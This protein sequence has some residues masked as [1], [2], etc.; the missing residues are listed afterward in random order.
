MVLNAEPNVTAGFKPLLGPGPPAED[1]TM[2]SWRYVY[3]DAGDLVGTSDARGCGSNFEY[4]AAGRL[5]AEDYSPCLETQPSY[6]ATSHPTVA[7]LYDVADPDSPLP[8]DPIANPGT[9]TIDPMLLPGRLASVSDRAAKTVT[10]YDGRGRVV[11]IGRKVAKPKDPSLPDA[12][13]AQRYAPR[14]YT[15]GTTYDGADRPVDDST[16]S[17]TAELQ[18][19][20][21]KSVVSTTYTARGTVG[22]VLGSYGTLV[23]G[24]THD[25]DGLVGSIQYGDRANT[26]TDYTYDNRRRVHSV[27]TYRGPPMDGSWSASPY[28]DTQQ[29]LLED[30]DYTYDVV[31]NPTE[32]RDWRI[33]SEWP[34]G[35]KPVSRKIQYDDLYRATKVDYQYA[36]G[37]DEWKSPF[38]KENSEI[39]VG[40]LDPLRPRPSPHVQFDKRMLEQSFS[41]DW[42]GNTTATDDDAHGFYDRSLGAVTNDSDKRYQLKTATQPGA[43]GGLLNATYDDAGNLVGLNVARSGPCLGG[44]CTQAFRYEWDEV[45]RIQRA[46]RWDGTTTPGGPAAVELQYAYDAH[47]QRVRKTAIDGG[48]AEQ[49]HTLY[50][51]DSLE[52]RRATWTLDTV[53]TALDYEQTAATEA[54][55]LLAHG[56]RLARL[57]YHAAASVPTVTDDLHV[58]LEMGDHL[59]STAIVLD[60]GTGELVEAGTYTAYG[61][62]ESDYRPGRWGSFREDYRFTGKEEDTEVGLTYFGKRYL[63][64]HL[65][66]WVSADPLSIHSFEG[67]LNTYAYVRGA[68]LSAKDPSGLNPV[69][70]GLGVVSAFAIAFLEPEIANAPGPEDKPV[71]RKGMAGIALHAIS[72]EVPIVGAAIDIHENLVEKGVLPAP[73]PGVSICVVVATKG[74]A[75]RS[76]AGG[77]AKVSAKP[78]APATTKSSGSTKAVQDTAAKP[79]V[80]SDAAAAPPVPDAPAKGAAEATAAP[81]GAR[82]APRQAIDSN[83]RELPEGVSRTPEQNAAARAFYRNNRNKAMERWEE[84]TGQSWPKNTNGEPQWCEH[85]RALKEYPLGEPRSSARTS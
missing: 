38:A 22:K 70:V 19:M 46:K 24:V 55:Y 53:E 40:I 76:L 32:I 31:D 68:I 60:R 21:G 10:S 81:K 64:P 50:I 66:R 34:E 9:L 72:Y 2:K 14:W 11:G 23:D 45:G 57:A 4:D 73:P 42:L 1:P 6:A 48:A 30:L 36:A 75:T 74:G 49:H 51:F 20:G 69:L 28:P 85:P 7:Y 62:A 82:G 80:A 39:A 26:K 18:G 25:A 8:G 13:L 29:T 52:L 61:S 44:S 67:G 47:D 37:T 78:R 77:A 84:R 35:A 12:A 56:V 54:V 59:G 33:A 83:L 15:S 58:F 63:S 27:Q 3:D 16:G 41:Y 65:G 71:M 43:N 17:A 79:A 5:T